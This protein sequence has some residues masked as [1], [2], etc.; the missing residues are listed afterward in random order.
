VRDWTSTAPAAHGANV[1]H[2][3]NGSQAFLC[4]LECGH[5][6]AQLP[7]TRPDVRVGPEPS[8]KTDSRRITLKLCD[9]M[10]KVRRNLENHSVP[11]ACVSDFAYDPASA[12]FANLQNA[13]AK[14]C[15]A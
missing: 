6:I 5:A 7:P 8:G 4:F 14:R 1:N 10:L 15:R 13:A 2:G 12:D 9:P 11:K 3:E